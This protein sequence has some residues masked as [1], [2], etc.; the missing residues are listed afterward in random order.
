MPKHSIIRLIHDE[1]ERSMKKTR[2]SR[3]G[4]LTNVDPQNLM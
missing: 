2:E 4:P 1:V 3:G